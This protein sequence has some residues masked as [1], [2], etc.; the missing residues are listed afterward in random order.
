MNQT[1]KYPK[2]ITIKGFGTFISKELV[3]SSSFEINHYPQNTVITTDF[4]KNE[5]INTI[6]NLNEID[7]IWELKGITEKNLT[8]HAQN[9]LF[10]NSSNNIIT[11]ISF[12]ELTF[13]NN[14]INN[15]S[16]GEFPLVGHYIGEFKLETQDWEISCYGDKENVSQIQDQSKNWNIQ[17]EGLNL[18]LKKQNASKDELLFKANDITLLLSL[19]LGSDI[20]F[21]RQLYYQ[22][23]ELC[24]ENWRRKADHNFGAGACVPD[25]RLDYFLEKTLGNYEKWDKNKKNNFYSTVSGINSSSNGFLEVRLLRIC[26]AWEG[27]A[28]SWS[29]EEKKS[30]SDLIP[31]KKLLKNTVDQYDVPLGYDKN[32]IKDRISKSLDWDKLSESLV[33]FSNQYNLDSERL[34]LDFKGLI[35]I[36]NDIAHSGL[37]RKEYSAKYL[38]DLIYNLKFGL[39]IVLLLELEYDGWVVTKENDWK[40]YTKIRELLKPKS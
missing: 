27:L 14:H 36:R 19:A 35:S 13:F 12:K 2:I 32:I 24:E 15:F 29:I 23:N 5:C 8:V 9:L 6:S 10:T 38:T 31:L 26:I 17:L 20:V 33:R 30:K 18:K 11:L 40:T 28:E 21:N 16:I 1:N 37:F 34:E 4:D 22:E 39:Q 7:S 3:F 25:F